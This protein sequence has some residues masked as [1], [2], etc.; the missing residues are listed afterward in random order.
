MLLLSGTVKLFRY[1]SAAN[2][3]QL[4]FTPLRTL[5]ND[6]AEACQLHPCRILLLSI[7]LPAVIDTSSPFLM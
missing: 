6:V 2:L 5:Q 7:D 3:L 4:Q 1:A